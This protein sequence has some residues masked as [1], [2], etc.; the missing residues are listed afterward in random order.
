MM[1]LLFECDEKCSLRSD[2]TGG[3]WERFA[4]HSLIGVVQIGRDYSG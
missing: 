3:P 1:L 2:A 4:I